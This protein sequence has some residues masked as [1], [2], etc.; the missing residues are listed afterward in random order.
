VRPESDRYEIISDS[1][2]LRRSHGLGCA[3]RTLKPL[4]LSLSHAW[5]RGPGRMSSS[6]A[7]AAPLSHDARC[8]TARAGL[9]VPHPAACPRRA[10]ASARQCLRRIFRHPHRG[11][12]RSGATADRSLAPAAPRQRLRSDRL[13]LRAADSP[14][15][16]ILA[17]EPTAIAL[18]VKPTFG[19]SW[20]GLPDW[21][22]YHSALK[23]HA[24]KDI[25]RRRKRLE[26]SGTLEFSAIE[27]GEAAAPVIDWIVRHKLAQLARS[28]RRGPWLETGEYGSLLKSA[29]RRG[30]RSGASRSSPSDWT[31]RS[32]LPP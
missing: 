6:T 29:A 28:E 7:A 14:F 21:N 8:R 2:N 27:D 19:V 31:R 24:R 18:A 16:R 30:G 22:S 1:M 3:G 23:K 9:A 10:G 5:C 25:E 13:R 17:A 20:E 11:W 4:S 26:Q 15:Q 12:T 32:S